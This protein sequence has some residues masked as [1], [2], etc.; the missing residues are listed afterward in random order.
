MSRK[1]MHILVLQFKWDS[2]NYL[3]SSWL[4]HFHVPMTLTCTK[5]DFAFLPLIVSVLFFVLAVVIF[6]FFI[7]PYETRSRTKINMCCQFCL[8]LHPCP[9]MTIRNSKHY[10][11]WNKT[12]SFLTSHPFLFPGLTLRIDCL[13]S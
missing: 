11:I 4:L 2:L 12:R 8:P 3:T 5:T 6:V 9:T 7:A 10:L 13:G 1:D